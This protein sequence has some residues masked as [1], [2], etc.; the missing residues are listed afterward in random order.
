MDKI[1]LMIN[2]I[3]DLQENELLFENKSKGW[4]LKKKEWIE[5]ESLNI[6]KLGLTILWTIQN[7]HLIWRRVLFWCK[8]L[9]F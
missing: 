1:A 9:L 2:A 7:K 5:I 4:I 6:I 3:M 8:H